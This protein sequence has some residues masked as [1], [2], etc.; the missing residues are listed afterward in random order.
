MIIGVPCEIKSDE[1]RVAMLPVG[2]EELTRRGHT[3]LIQKD[4]GAGSGI[5]DELY[6]EHG[7]GIVD[8][9]EEVFER[10]ELIVKVK[11]PQPGLV[12]KSELEEFRGNWS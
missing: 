4:A 10:A 12:I 6:Q 11:E 7:A 1:Y 9:T 5:P 8:S 3:V 2:A